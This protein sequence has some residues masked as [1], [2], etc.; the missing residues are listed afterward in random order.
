MLVG[1]VLG[2]CQ[3]S[4]Q[5]MFDSLQGDYEIEERGVSLQI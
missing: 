5:N 2:I 4:Y 3:T 1:I